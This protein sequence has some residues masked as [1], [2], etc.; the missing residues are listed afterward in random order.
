M[1]SLLE[2]H[3][4]TSNSAFSFSMLCS[5]SLNSS[6]GRIT[7]SSRSLSVGALTWT[8]P[9]GLSTPFI[10]TSPAP[11]LAETARPEMPLTVGEVIGPPPRPPRLF[12][13][14]RR[15][16]ASPLMYPLYP[17][18]KCIGEAAKGLPLAS[19]LSS[20]SEGFLFFAGLWLMGE[21][22][23]HGSITSSPPTCLMPALESTSS[24][25]SSSS[26]SSSI[27]TLARRNGVELNKSSSSPF[28]FEHAFSHGSP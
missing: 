5:S 19:L 11:T 21:S 8:V 14:L 13:T 17:V 28:I 24:S 6:P 4:I 23:S 2:D 27:R 15:I 1:K 25:L 12:P 22:K 26:A 7:R 18:R 20:S 3:S 10:C 16:L 9:P